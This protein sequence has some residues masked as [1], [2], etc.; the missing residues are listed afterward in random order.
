[1]CIP[2]LCLGQLLCDLLKRTCFLIGLTDLSRL[3]NPCISFSLFDVN[4]QM[5]EKG[6]VKKLDFYVI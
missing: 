1:M 2:D 6:E 4:K 5:S 3:A